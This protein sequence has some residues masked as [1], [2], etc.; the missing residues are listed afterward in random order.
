MRIEINYSDF[1]TDKKV[2]SYDDVLSMK[3]G[4]VPDAR[5]EYSVVWFSRKHNLHGRLT[6]GQSIPIEDSMYFEAMPIR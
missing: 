5:I 3:Y 2:L 1:E 6:P 4:F